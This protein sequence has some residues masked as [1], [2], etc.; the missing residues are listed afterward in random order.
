[1]D[2]ASGQGVSWDGDGGFNDSAP[3]PKYPHLCHEFHSD[4]KIL[5]TKLNE[6]EAHEGV[7]MPSVT[8]LFKIFNY[9]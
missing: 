9:S 4:L 7:Q 1:L 8:L 2:G 6:Q 3:K 5:L